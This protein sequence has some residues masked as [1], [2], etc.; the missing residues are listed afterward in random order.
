MNLARGGAPVEAIMATHLQELVISASDAETLAS[1]LE[2]FRRVPA[3]ESATE[4]LAG[5]IGEA[6]MVPHESLPA[7]RVAMNSL[8]SYEEE[9]GAVRRRVTLAYP[10]DADADAGRVSVLSPIGL[11]LLGR[12]EGA[13]VEPDTPGGKALKI[14]I[15]STEQPLKQERAAPKASQ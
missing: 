6:R 11:A 14:R 10:V 9:P 12:A 3:V 8:V 7:D 2:D 15:L 5:I 4:T 1:M 13:V